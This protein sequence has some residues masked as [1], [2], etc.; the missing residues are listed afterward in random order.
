ML[1]C[2]HSI[3]RRWSLC[4]SRMTP[5]APRSAWCSIFKRLQL[6]NVLS[7]NCERLHLVQ[8]G[9]FARFFFGINL[10]GDNPFQGGS[11]FFGHS[12]IPHMYGSQYSSQPLREIS[13]ARWSLPNRLIENRARENDLSFA[14]KALNH[15]SIEIET[16]KWF[17]TNLTR[18]KCIYLCKV[19]LIKHVLSN[20]R[21][22]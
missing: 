10:F 16:K 12:L 6:V 9:H 14:T 8:F 7:V 18:V 21:S 11:D 20:F 5:P 22:A 2:I 1:L 15:I 13:T 19:S 17:C 3:V 4:V